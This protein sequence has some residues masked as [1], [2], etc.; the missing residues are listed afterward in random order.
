MAIWG[1]RAAKDTRRRWE[2]KYRMRDF[3]RRTPVDKKG[4]Q[5]VRVNY[6][7]KLTIIIFWM[8][9]EARSRYTTEIPNCVTSIHIDTKSLKFK[10]KIRNFTRHKNILAKWSHRSSTNFWIRFTTVVAVFWPSAQENIPTDSENVGSVGDDGDENYTYY[11]S[12]PE[13][14]KYKRSVWGTRFFKW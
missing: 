5:L 8:F 2:P 14:W 6:P 12:G 10:I 9:F 1:N 7:I 4:K 13:F 3:H 11:E